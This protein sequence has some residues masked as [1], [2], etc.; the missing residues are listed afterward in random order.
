MDSRILIIAFALLTGC[1]NVCKIG[2]YELDSNEKTYSVTLTSKIHIPYCG[3][4]Y[5]S[6]EQEMGYS[7]I[8]DVQSYFVTVDSLLNEANP[9][10]RVERLEDTCFTFKIPAGT[11]FVYHTD[12][13]LSLTDYMETYGSSNN[14]EV[15][16]DSKCYEKWMN[17]PDYK[18]TVT[19]NEDFQLTY[20]SRCF[21]GTNPC[22]S[23][24]GPY[25]P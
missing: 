21:T 1:S 8:S 23:Y 17:T 11:Y 6:P 12:K 25:P 22:M 13:A 16:A 19:K 14:N 15:A 4:A 5:P 9:N 10:W 18:F 24:D 3:G 2:T 20:R 7:K